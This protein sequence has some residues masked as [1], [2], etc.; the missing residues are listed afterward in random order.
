M[1]WDEDYESKNESYK[2][3]VRENSLYISANLPETPRIGERINL[4]SFNNDVIFKCG[5]I[6]DIEHEIIIS[7]PYDERGNRK[8]KSYREYVHNESIYISVILPETP[9]IGERINLSSFNRDVAFNYGFIYDIDHVITPYTQR[10]TIWVHPFKDYYHHWMKM[11]KKYEF[12]E[13][14]SKMISSD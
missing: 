11:K 9:K 4:S 10:I 13:R 3:Y 12:D 6:Y 8:N 1:P 7:I 5:Y 14:W 2:K